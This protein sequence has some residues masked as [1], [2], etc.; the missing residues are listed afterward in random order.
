LQEVFQY[1][2]QDAS[3]SIN[4]REMNSILQ[5][6]NVNMSRAQLEKMMRNAD[7]DRKSF[8]TTFFTFI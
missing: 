7:L 8:M 2:D 6:L 4:A 5:K 1:A 3:G